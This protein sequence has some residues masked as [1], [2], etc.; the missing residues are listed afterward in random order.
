[1]ICFASPC[2]WPNACVSALGGMRFHSTYLRS[3]S[4]NQRWVHDLT[5]ATHLWANS[6]VSA[7]EDM[8]S[9]HVDYQLSHYCDDPCSCCLLVRL[10]LVPLIV[11]CLA[12]GVMLLDGPHWGLGPI[13]GLGDLVSNPLNVHFSRTSPSQRVRCVRTPSMAAPPPA[14]HSHTRACLCVS[15]SRALPTS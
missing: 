15:S 7:L 3:N 9:F 11:S 10:A 1:M 12:P 2:L 14:V 6:V 13:Q 5:H 8:G 4:S